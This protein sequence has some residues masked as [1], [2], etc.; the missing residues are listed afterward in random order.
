MNATDPTAYI[1]HRAPM[2]AI[3]TVVSVDDESA[4]A[5]RR[6]APGD[7]V[8]EGELW[9]PG[10]VEG[11]AQTAGVLNGLHEKRT[12]TR[13]RKGML[14]AVRRF[15]VARRARVGELVRFRVDLIRR[16]TPLTLM[17]CVVAVGEEVLAR[18]EMKFYVEV[19]P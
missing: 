1:P 15:D 9:E 12:G 2:L 6:V 5:E 14:V 17:R 16:I 11:L 3:D 18:G 10:L 4:V 13:S 19:A 8:V 7:D